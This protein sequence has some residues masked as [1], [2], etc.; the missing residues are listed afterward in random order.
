MYKDEVMEHYRTA[1]ELR[2]QLEEANKELIYY[3]NQIGDKENESG[4]HNAVI[5]QEI[6]E[7]MGNKK[8]TKARIQRRIYKNKFL[9]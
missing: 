6:K 9:Y 1:N 4:H 2:K 7:A 8:K 5:E 3:K